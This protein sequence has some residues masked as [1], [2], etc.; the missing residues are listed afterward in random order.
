MTHLYSSTNRSEGGLITQRVGRR[1]VVEGRAVADPRRQKGQTNEQKL[2]QA[3]FNAASPEVVG[4]GENATKK[5]GG[6]AT[7]E[8][9]KNQGIPF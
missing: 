6:T 5:G 3:F 8:I 4:G 1:Q 7:R 2:D 9:E